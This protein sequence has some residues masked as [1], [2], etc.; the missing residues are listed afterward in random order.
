M[1]LTILQDHPNFDRNSCMKRLKIILLMPKPAFPCKMFLQILEKGAQR[2]FFNTQ[3]E[4]ACKCIIS[5]TQ[6]VAPA[7]SKEKMDFKQQ[8]PTAVYTNT[9]LGNTL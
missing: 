4:T 1:Q 2:F 5:F 3:G 6:T 7:S 8:L 9:H